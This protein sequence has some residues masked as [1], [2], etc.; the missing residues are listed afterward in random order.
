MF[1][2]MKFLLVTLILQSALARAQTVFTAGPEALGDAGR[3]A[4]NPIDSHFLNPA[5]MAFTKG[6][7]FGGVFQQGQLSA[8]SPKNNY[9]LVL[10]DNDTDKIASA[11]FGYAYKRQ[12]YPNNT[13]VDQDFS[14]DV[15]M[16]IVPTIAVGVQGHRL[17]RSSQLTSS[18]TKHNASVGALVVPTPIFGLSFTA[19]DIL[20]DDDLDLIPVLSLGTHVIIM[21]I[22]RLRADIWRQEKKNPDHQGNLGLGLEIV[23]AEGFLIRTGG[24][25]DNLNKQT[26]WT[27][28]LAWEGPRLSVAYGYKNNINVAGDVTHTF[29]A[30]ISF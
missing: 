1:S 10:S 28:G 17:V 9:A 21:E 18:F 30:W 14:L 23:G 7:N 12:S 11:S 4:I 2:A 5:A 27:A 13:I 20:P 24:L 8:D 16:R 19:Y 29:Q 25:W 15:A 22:L 26:Y 6:Y 3:A